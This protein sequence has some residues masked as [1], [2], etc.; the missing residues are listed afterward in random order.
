M[1][2]PELELV[3]VYHCRSRVVVHAFQSILHA[4]SWPLLHSLCQPSS[5]QH[6]GYQLDR[7]L[8]IGMVHILGIRQVCFVM[9]YRLQAF[10]ERVLYG[11]SQSRGFWL[12]D[13]F[14]QF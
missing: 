14:V 9:L 12:G 1:L 4:H 5:P 10:G 7:Y 6:H 8:K 3:D 11:G 13:A 2:H